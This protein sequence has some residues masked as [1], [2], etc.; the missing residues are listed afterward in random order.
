MNVARDGSGMSGSAGAGWRRLRPLFGWKQSA[1][2]AVLLALCAS[3][4]VESRAVGAPETMT[5]V[6]VESGGVSANQPI[7]LGE[8][9]DGLIELNPVGTVKANQPVTLSSGPGLE[10]QAEPMLMMDL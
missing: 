5:P 10:R 7:A 1:V 9:D 3:A 2:A 4:R 6:V 8:F